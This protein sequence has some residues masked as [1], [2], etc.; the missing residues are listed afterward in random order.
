MSEGA[1]RGPRDE[2]PGRSIRDA[3]K[4]IRD[5]TD[6]DAPAG[7]E[8]EALIAEVGRTLREVTGEHGDVELVVATNRITY[9]DDAVYK[10]DAREGN[11]AFELFR[12][13]LRRITFKGGVTDLEIDT[14][15]RRFAECR[16]T[17]K[18]D[19]DF[20]STLW[21]ESLTGV[22]YVAMDGFT[23]KLFMADERF[24][25]GFRG[26][27]NEVCPG[28]EDLEE[29]DASD[30]S[31]RPVRSLV[32]ADDITLVN[33]L[34][35]ASLK[36]LSGPARSARDAALS[37]QAP[38]V[39]YEHVLRL[40]ASF[41]VKHPCAL[42]PVDLGAATAATLAALLAQT[43]EQCFA[44]GARTMLALAEAADHFP[45][46]ARAHL[47][48]L[49]E[50]VTGRDSLSAVLLSYDAR[51]PEYTAWLRWLYI[52]GQ[53]L[54]APDLLDL[55]N[56]SQVGPRQD[57]LKD[58]LRRQG[59]SSLDPW[60]DRLRDD[61]PTVV[62]EV[63]DV[64]LGSALGEQAQPLLVELLRHRAPE[65][66]ARAVDGFRGDYSPA[67]RQA[68]LPLLRD[69]ASEVRRAVLSRFIEGHD[70]SVGT[71]VAATVRSPM[72]FEFDEDEQRQYFESLATLCGE[73]FLEVFRERLALEDAQSSGLGK[74]L[75]RGP[76]ALP[77]TSV[78]RAAMS[79][80]AIVATPKAIA[81]LREV[82]AKADLELA[83]Q[84]EVALRLAQRAEPQVQER[85]AL[86]HV[87][88]AEDS[89]AVV[90]A[91]RPMMGDRIL[92]DP[93]SL[94]VEPP[95]R[96]RPSGALDLGA[97]SRNREAARAPTGLPSEGR[98]QT[99]PIS[100][101]LPLPSGRDQLDYG[102]LPLLAVG[103]HFLPGDERRL[104]AEP[105][106]LDVP[107]YHLAALRVMLVGVEVEG[108]TATGP[109]HVRMPTVQAGRRVVE[110]ATRPVTHGDW[111]HQPDASLVD[112][113]SS[114]LDE[115]ARAVVPLATPPEAVVKRPTTGPAKPAQTDPAKPAQAGA[116]VDDMLK[117]FLDMDLGD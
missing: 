10:S 117:Q 48:A 44:D 83:S 20:V 14:F 35:C 11:L 74:L 110:R 100:Q 71:Y 33:R 103:E 115:E 98:P 65:V 62:L 108:L 114:Y 32:A 39:A 104:S 60:A 87:P 78:R 81:L 5:L 80:L 8:R 94:R 61:N 84:C 109:Q 86:T 66:R 47:T 15:V 26:V 96:V 95:A 102:D 113:V 53:G 9:G 56:V 76:K 73:K 105:S 50:S 12:Q 91:G 43:D 52:S 25:S 22:T 17:E 51:R 64:I 16:E 90:E 85:P 69:P 21:R 55:I 38:G 6:D 28:L 101:V 75:N 18:V 41:A 30:P 70:G 19:E 106:A 54:S 40:L 77:D 58:L 24:T 27:I 46:G 1:P 23:E 92:F 63:L 67:I 68:L 49:R 107:G 3:L 97:T 82:H 36:G 2:G 42:T 34:S 89:S 59:T 111:S 116:S 57:L 4:R 99:A 29:D 7:A 72:F 79:G 31:P 93:M 13:G 112:I 45:P 88:S 37:A